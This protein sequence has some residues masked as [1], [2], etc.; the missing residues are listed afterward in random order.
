MGPA[1]YG[2]L[3]HPSRCQGMSVQL[4]CYEDRGLRFLGKKQSPCQCTAGMKPTTVTQVWGKSN[5]P[6]QASSWGNALRKYPDLHS[7]RYLGSQ[8]Q[9][10]SLI[11]WIHTVSCREPKR[12][13]PTLSMK[14]HRILVNLCRLLL[15]SFSVLWLLSMISLRRSCTLSLTFFKLW[16]FS[17]NFGCSFWGE[18]MS[19][20]LCHS[21]CF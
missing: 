13:L 11:A 20:L 17:C 9:R 18:L 1:S 15:L 16:S 21:S 3:P 7:H 2:W 4:W 8:G 19:K 14:S 6:V 12:L 10:S 5:D